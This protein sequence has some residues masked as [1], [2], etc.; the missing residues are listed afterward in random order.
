MSKEWLQVS[1][2]H[3]LAG[4]VPLC[5]SEAKNTV[6][7]K[8]L[9]RWLNMSRRFEACGWESVFTAYTECNLPTERMMNIYLKGFYRSFTEYAIGT[10]QV[11]QFF[12]GELFNDSILRFR[13]L[14]E[15]YQELIKKELYA[16]LASNIPSFVYA[17][18]QCSEVGI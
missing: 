13:E 5:E 17:A 8:D 16:N 4:A 14:N 1:K 18:A 12:S 6:K 9:S 3:G 10:E 7:L 2:E 11:L 15:Q